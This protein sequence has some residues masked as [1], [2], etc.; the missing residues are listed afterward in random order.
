MSATSD[1]SGA[2]PR[3]F[4]SGSSVACLSVWAIWVGAL[5]AM[6]LVFAPALFKFLPRP[7]AGLVAGRLFTVLAW[8]SVYVPGLLAALALCAGCHLGW[9]SWLA[10]VLI[11][12]LSLLGIY[13][14][15]PLMAELR[16]A[17]QALAQQPDG[18]V[19]ADLA[20]RFAM[21]HRFSAGVY[22]VQMLLALGW[23][24]RHFSLGQRGCG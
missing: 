12:V 16:V 19:G 24:W 21:L 10:L 3:F 1:F 20:N 13:V 15:Q 11:V 22:G 17:M 9:R 6:A 18:V 14:L 7:E 23:G 2:L 4:R 8:I 5:W